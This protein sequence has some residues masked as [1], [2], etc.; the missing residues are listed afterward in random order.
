MDN[1]IGG[2]LI[3]L[4]RYLALAGL[5]SRRSVEALIVRGE[6][7]VNGEKVTNPA[8]RIAPEKDT[9]RAMGNEI[10]VSFLPTYIVLNK[11]PG[12]ITTA[13]D[14]KKRTTV[15]NLVKLPV[16]VFPVGRLDRE[17]EG[18][19]LLTNDGEL[20]YRLMHPKYKIAKKYVVRL[21]R[22]FT[23][24]MAEKFRKGV[25]IDHKYRVQG[26]IE[27]PSSPGRKTVVATISEGRNRQIRKMFAML[28][29]RVIG[30][31][32][33]AIGPI[34]LGKLKLG[35]WRYLSQSELRTLQK[36]VGLTH[37]NHE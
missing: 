31:Q 29:V 25:L 23:D 32:R 34:R 3:R 36:T 4:N 21:N 16:R 35:Q 1:A 9:I 17:S 13:R 11:P 8:L 14:E 10:A 6:V 5:G 28:R 18:L 27:F 2:N 20:A 15:F 30:L 22:A 19:L 7:Y 12:Y 37:G 24:D 26:K 33:I